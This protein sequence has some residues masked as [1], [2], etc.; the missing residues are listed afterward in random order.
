[1]ARKKSVHCN[2][3]R[4]KSYFRRFQTKLRRRREGKTDYKQRRA[5][6]KQDANKQ[7]IA[8]N[9]VVVRITNK[10]VICQVVRAY[11]DGDRTV[12]YADSTELKKYGITF[13]L[14]NY[15]ACYATGLLL[16]RRML[17]K[18]DLAEQ[19]PPKETDGEFNMV[20]H[21][22][23]GLRTFVCY[24]DI[25]L[26]RST[27]GARIFA[28][29]KGCS[30]GGLKIPHSPK[31]FFG[32]NN[33]ELNSEEL[34]NRI[35]GKSVSDFMIHLREND[36]TKFKKQFSEYIKLNISPENLEEIYEK[37]FNE[38]KSNPEKEI[39]EKK[40]Y[41]SFKQ[42]KVKKLTSEERAARVAAKK[43]AMKAEN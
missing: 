35:F 26:R 18:F 1:M 8:K 22:E 31:N 36:P 20:E 33:G 38:I 4:K 17:Q 21:N 11:L 24:L 12:A 3:L 40:D 34:R 27:K 30:D 28:A 13:G 19:Y 32:Y 15:S 39:K 5:L 9:R 7:G 16:A 14:T 25:G 10:R 23:S 42:Y 37:A 6:I 43:E 41:S 29:M 2:K